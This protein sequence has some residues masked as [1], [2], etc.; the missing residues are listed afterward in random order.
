MWWLIPL[1][2]AVLALGVLAG[3]FIVFMWFVRQFWK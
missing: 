2:I 3:I 1:L